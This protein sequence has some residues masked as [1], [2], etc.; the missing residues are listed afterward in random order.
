MTMVPMVSESVT[1]DLGLLWAAWVA[2]SRLALLVRG[3]E[4]GLPRVSCQ[5]VSGGRILRWR[6][7]ETLD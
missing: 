6:Q 2:F 4:S 7:R 5:E 3:S 1:S